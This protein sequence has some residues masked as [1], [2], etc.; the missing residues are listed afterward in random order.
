MEFVPVAE[1]T[2]QARALTGWVLET[3]LRQL[4][5]W[6]AAGAADLH[7]AINLTVADLLD[8][9]LPESIGAAL[10]NWRVAADAL[11]VEV[12]E[13]SVLA[14]PVRVGAVLE[15]LGAMGV[16][17]SLDDFGTGYSSLTHL[18]ELPV[19]EVKVDRSFV[20]KM[21]ADPAD[22]AIVAS[23][24]ALAQALRI[25]VV[26]EGVEDETTWAALA[27]LDCDLVQGYAFSKPLPASALAPL[28]TP[29]PVNEV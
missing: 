24:I 23:T 3:G 14:D 29:A 20:A 12:T 13:T 22:A 11:V 28:L 6:R 9:A 1:Q 2:G 25:R 4:R 17:V 26:A 10:A 21:G 7:L 27:A 16:T 15:R 19:G 8:A 5:R 18:K